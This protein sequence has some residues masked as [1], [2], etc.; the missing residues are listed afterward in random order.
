MSLIA[1]VAYCNIIFFC[2][3]SWSIVATDVHVTFCERA[4]APQ[5]VELHLIH[6]FFVIPLLRRLRKEKGESDAAVV[7]KNL[8]HKSFFP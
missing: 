7:V 6:S 8:S 1:L 3:T 4:V 5:L 2:F